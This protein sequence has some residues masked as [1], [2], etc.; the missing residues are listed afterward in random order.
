MNEAAD[1][2]AMDEQAL[3]T[4]AIQMAAEIAALRRDV[5]VKQQRIDLITHE[6]AYLRR[7][8]F[9]ASRE[10]LN[11]DQRRLFEEIIE[12]D[13]EAASLE[14]K[15]LCTAESKSAPKE[16]PRRT[17]LPAHLT[18]VEIRH[19]L[20]EA[21]CSCGCTLKRI[22]EDVAEKLDYNPGT[23]R[24]E[25]HIRGKY[26]CRQCQTLVQAPVPAHVIDKGL[27]TPGLLA[28]IA[29]SKHID[30]L[31]LYRQ[32]AMADRVEVPLARSTQAQWLGRVGVELAPLVEALRELMLTRPVLHADETPVPMLD[33][34]R[35]QTQTAYIW[36]YA[37][38][39]YDPLRAVIYDFASG[40][41]GENAR[42]FLEDWNGTLVC[43]DY[44]GY[45]AFF[46]DRKVDDAVIKA[47]V[48]EA[49]CM[50]HA[51]RKFY[52]VWKSIKSPVAADAV[53]IIRT[54]YD[55]ERTAVHLND[56]E[57]L[58]LRQLNSRPIMD[59]YLEWLK[60]QRERATHGTVIV[61]A[62]DYSLNRWSALSRFLEDGAVPIDNNEVE[63]RIRPIALGRRNWLFA[64]SLRGGQR[65]A[66]I[67]SLLQ[68][69]MLNGIEPFT[70]LKD[71]LARLPTHKANRIEELLPHQ[72][73][74]LTA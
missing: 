3:R 25:R 22:G 33:P 11:P 8:K 2:A 20:T 44:G 21:V 61:S 70:Y 17:P 72:W 62:I 67:L 14:L 37:T 41:A 55:I 9:A 1:I 42:Q 36:A 16:K 6:L 39:R 31:P 35:G 73:Q 12:A 49:G 38:T 18:R 57:R 34:G 23:F 45:A 15:A 24:V 64:G 71:V 59:K 28:H 4:L 52:D 68:T 60:L 32:E 46:K 47:C 5:A 19:E 54:L 56:S 69:A 48:I 29:V 50:A 27:P 74:P 66:A 65:S 63:N 30:H 51:R 7:L 13:L 53:A 26:V 40:R 10:T 58:R 43:D